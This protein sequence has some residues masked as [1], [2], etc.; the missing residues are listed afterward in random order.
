MSRNFDPHPPP[1]PFFLYSLG[2]PELFSTR[3][4]ENQS[5]ENC[6]NVFSPTKSLDVESLGWPK[7]RLNET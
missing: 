2:S 7:M 5:G 6:L 3:A 1:T 4:A